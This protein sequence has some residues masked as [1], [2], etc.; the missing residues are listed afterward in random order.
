MLAHNNSDG[1]L[2][3]APDKFKGS[4]SAAV[5]AAAL[6]DGLRS[7]T[8]RPVV[9]FPIA[10]GG[11]GT[12]DMLMTAGF[13]P[14]TCAAVDPLGRP[15]EMVYARSGRTAVIEAAAA[16]G[17][18]LLRGCGPN[19]ATARIATSLG[20][21]M[22]LRDALT[23]GVDRIVLG[24][25]GSATT[26]GGA[27]LLVG[28]GARLLDEHDDPVYPSGADLPNI[29]SIDLSGVDRGLRDVELVVA[30]DVDNPLTGPDGAAHVYGR[31]KGADPETARSLDRALVH[32]AD[33]V[34]AHTGQDRRGAP[35]MGAAGGIAFAM[36]ALLG[37]RVTPGI[38]LLLELGG[39]PALLDGAALVI[40][41]EGSLDEQS[42]RGKGPVGV[43]RQAHA[44]GVPVVAVAGRSTVG[45][46]ET[47]SAGIGSVYTLAEL[48]ADQTVS[49]RNAVALLNLVGATIAR[50]LFGEFG[51]RH[52]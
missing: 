50:D 27:G 32:W 11:E 25:G 28:L 47:R 29:R 37:A 26:D 36:A 41:G 17:L 16:C 38:D 23:H 18:A 33:I 39:F 42:L 44:R 48:E 46:A 13:S 15:V 24:I 35:G 21:G 1:H 10:D 3:V 31:Q 14:V 2:V 8:S 4:V 7:A 49:M 45:S 51:S 9:P 43:A 52:P 12:V 30:C 34:T 40:V 19:R 5:A 22:A 20:V 6:T